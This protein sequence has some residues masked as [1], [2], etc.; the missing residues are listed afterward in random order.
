MLSLKKLAFASRGRGGKF[1]GEKV[2]VNNSSEGFSFAFMSYILRMKHRI[3]FRF[4]VVLP[5]TL[6]F[7]P[8]PNFS[9]LGKKNFR[10]V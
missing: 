9:T 7:K 2:Q 4:V 5:F 1:P 10:F 3:D 8:N 6:K